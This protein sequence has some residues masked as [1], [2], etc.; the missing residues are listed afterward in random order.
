MCSKLLYWMRKWDN[1]YRCK[2]MDLTIRV[3]I[4]DKTISILLSK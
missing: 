4:K 2:E 3:Q 1:F